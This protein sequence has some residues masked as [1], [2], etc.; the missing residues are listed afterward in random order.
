MSRYRT[1]SRQPSHLVNF[2]H[3]HTEKK[4]SNQ[5]P[6]RLHG[7]LSNCP[8]GVVAHRDELWVEVQTQD[9]HE[10]SWKTIVQ[11]QLVICWAAQII[12]IFPN[13]QELVPTDCLSYF[14]PLCY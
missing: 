6:T 8:G 3:K 2:T 11:Q 9:G 10:L 13:K 7:N 1:V 5:T 4:N 14:I 12:F